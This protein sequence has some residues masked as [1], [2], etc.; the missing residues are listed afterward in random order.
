MTKQCVYCETAKDPKLVLLETPTVIAALSP[1]PSAAG[2]VVVMPKQHCL[3]LGQVPDAVMGEMFT[4]ASKV[5]SVLFESLGAQGTNL[6]VQNGVEAGQGAEHPIIH[7]IPR[8]EGDNLNLLW[9]PKQASEDELGTA[10]LKLSAE[11]KHVGA[12]EEPEKPKPAESAAPKDVK[13]DEEDYLL[14]S[15]D[16][17]P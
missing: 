15:L 9:T 11:T 1:A 3:V 4:V 2:H 16:R 12:F 17:I 7:V 5:S 14:R 8:R 13:K 6:L 10:A